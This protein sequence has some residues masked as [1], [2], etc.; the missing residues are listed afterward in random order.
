MLVL[1]SHP[2]LSAGISSRDTVQLLPVLLMLNVRF[3]IITLLSL[4]LK[5]PLLK[6]TL[7]VEISEEGRFSE[8]DDGAE[9][10]KCS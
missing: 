3:F 9:L 5:P 6:A 2:L 8:S 4:M 1:L 10:A 7:N